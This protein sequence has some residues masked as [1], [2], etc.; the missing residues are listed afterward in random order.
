MLSVECLMLNVDN[1]IQGRA[2]EFA[3][4]VVRLVEHIQRRRSLSARAIARQLLNAGGSVGANLEEASAA[5]SKPDFIS[6]CSIAAKEARESRYWL[7]LLVACKLVD[8]K[9]LS[10]LVKEAG[11]IGAIITTIVKNAAKTKTRGATPA[12]PFNIQH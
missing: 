6:K 9:R 7:R 12:V 4:R 8:S 3:C 1:D 11:E 10:P 2:F 5:Q